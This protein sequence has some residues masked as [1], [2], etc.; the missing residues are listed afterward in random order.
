VGVAC[1]LAPV[2]Q[3]L[4]SVR[5]CAA[6]RS[7]ILQSARRQAATT[8]SR[9][10]ASAPLVGSAGRPLPSRWLFRSLGSRFM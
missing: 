6:R 5:S 1:A 10:P 2:A 9:A 7:R 3:P 4:G 8:A